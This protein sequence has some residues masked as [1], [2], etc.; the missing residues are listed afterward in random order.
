MMGRT[1][2]LTGWCAGLAAA[3]LLGI[4]SVYQ[5]LAFAATTAG[6]ALLPDLDHP[7]AKASRLLG[8][9]SRAVSWLLR[10]A[11]AA[12]YA[13]TKGPRDEKRTGT[14]RHLSHTVLFAVGLGFAT[15]AG[16]KA[17]GAWV[18]AA[19]VLLGLLLADA[20]LGDW[21]LPVGCAAVVV[22]VYKAPDVVAQLDALAG[23]L[24]VAVAL[25][26]VVH[27][28]GDA[29]TESGCPFLFPIPIAGETWYELRPPKVLRIRTGR[30]VEN[31]V[32][33]PAFAVLAVLLLPGVWAFTVATIGGVFDSPTASP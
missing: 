1:H 30:R 6:F 25:G 10:R 11:S 18:V 15:H 31:L 27:C 28:L 17:G 14:H 2:A 8:P 29:I 9:F 33:F 24:G 19:I 12:L 16:T 23:L 5:V 26:C 22:W 3:P 7:G 4:G 32:V 20:C 21:L 13:V